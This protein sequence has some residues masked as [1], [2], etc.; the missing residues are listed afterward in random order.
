[1]DHHDNGKPHVTG[2]VELSREHC[3][4]EANDLKEDIVLTYI[5]IEEIHIILFKLGLESIGETVD[6]ILRK[7]KWT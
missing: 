5:F 3:C 7:N 2:V 1:M 4:D 6:A